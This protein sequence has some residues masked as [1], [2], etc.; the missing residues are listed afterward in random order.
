MSSITQRSI[1]AYLGE[2][3]KFIAM[4]LLLTFAL[5][6]VGCVDLDG[7]DLPRTAD[8][9]GLVKRVDSANKQITIA[10]EKVGDII[11]Q[12]TMAYPVQSLEMLGGVTDDDSVAFTLKEDAPGDFMI[13]R[14]QK[15]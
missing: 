3:A 10:H 12:L 15:L 14:L 8:G 5:F 2:G 9:S 11:D 1:I 4:V 6:Y 13:T 7:V